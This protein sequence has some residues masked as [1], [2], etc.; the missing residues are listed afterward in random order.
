MIFHGIEI[1]CPVCGKDGELRL[2]RNTFF[3]DYVYVACIGCN[4]RT[5]A[6]YT[7]E[8]A[9]KDWNEKRHTN[10]KGQIVEWKEKE[11]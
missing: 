6:C 8:E 9:F 3:E 2:G 5:R 7:N 4:T 10:A 1:L 11:K